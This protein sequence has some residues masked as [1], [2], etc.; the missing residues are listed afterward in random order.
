MAKENQ[1]D[2][3]R[4]SVTIIV[5]LESATVTE[6]HELEE[7]LRVVASTLPQVQVNATYADERLRRAFP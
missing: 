4:V 3:R 6:A 1:P 7:A 2:E 5:R